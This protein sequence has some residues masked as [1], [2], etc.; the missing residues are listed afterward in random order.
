MSVKNQ[1]QTGFEIAVI[2]MSGRFPG[3]K[4]I[5][6]FWKNLKNGVESIIFFTHE[7]LVEAGVESQLLNDPNFVRTNGGLIENKYC[8]DASFFDYSPREAQI[9]DP[10]LRILHECVWSAIEHAGY[11]PHS[12]DGSIGIYTGARPNFDWE[13]LAVLSGSTSVI[14]AFASEQLTQRDYFNT[15]IAYKL[16]LKGPTML[17]QTACST[18]LVAIHM[19]SRAL[20]MG[21]CNIALAGGVSVSYAK[22]RGYRFIE[23]MIGASDGHVRAFD[24]DATGT[25]GGEGV[26]IIVL[27]RLKHAIADGD[28]IHAVIKGTGVNNDG[29]RK[30]GYTAPSILAQAELVKSVLH[31]AK[32]EPE[33]ITYIEAHGTGTPMG[34]PIEVE[35]LTRAFDTQDRQFCAIGSV[36]TN[37]GHLDAAAGVAG[38]IKTVLALKNKQIPPSLNFKTPNP[39]IDFEN[40]PFFVASTLK[41]WRN[42][43]YPLRAAV[44]SLGIGGTNAHVL[45]E[46]WQDTPASEQDSNSHPRTQTRDI[47][48]TAYQLILLSAKNRSALEKQTN[49]LMKFLEENP[50]VDFADTSYTLQVGRESFKHRNMWTINP[51]CPDFS[52]PW[53]AVASDSN[54]L[55]FMFPG[56]GTQYV[57]M[58]L[59]LYRNFPLFRETIDH[60]F[61]V[62]EP[63]LGYDIKVIL[64]PN[65]SGNKESRLYSEDNIKSQSSDSVDKINRT[66]LTQPLLF[67]IEYALA[68]LLMNWGIKPDAMIGHSIGEYTAACIAGVFSLED[69]LKLVALRGKMMQSMPAGAMLSVELSKKQLDT[70]LVLHPGVTIAAVNAPSLCVV[71]GTFDAIDGLENELTLNEYRCRRLQTSHA[72]HS[73]MMEPILKQFE[74]AVNTV[75]LKSPRQPFISNLTGKWITPEEATSPIY[76]AKHLRQAVQFAD[77]IAQVL[78]E[79]DAI[80]IEVGPSRSLST[81]AKKQFSKTKPQQ[82]VNLVKHPKEDNP[83]DEYLMSKIGQLWLNGVN[84][85]WSAFWREEKRKRIPLPSYPFEET[86]YRLEIDSL[87]E[88]MTELEVDSQLTKKQTL[89]NWFYTP[90]WKRITLPLSQAQESSDPLNWLIFSDEYGIGTQLEMVLKQ[91][92][93][94]NID[95][96]RRGTRFADNGS[97]GFTLN[98]Q[99]SDD[100]HALIQQLKQLDRTPHRIIHLWNLTTEN[101]KNNFSTGSLWHDRAEDNGFYSLVYFAQAMA[102]ENIS[103]EIFLSAVVNNMFEVTGEDALFPLQALVLGPAMVIPREHLNIKCRCI[104]I[105]FSKPGATK[106]KNLITQLADECGAI[107]HANA[108]I[109]AYRNSFR[110]VRTFEPTDLRSPEQEAQELPLKKNG[111]Y[112]VTGGLGGMGLTFAQYLSNAVSASLI[113]ISRSAFP[114]PNE[115]DSWL[116]AHESQDST[117]IK[118]LKLRD[119]EK[120]G[121]HIQVVQADVSDFQKMQSVIGEAE[122]QLGFINGVIHAAG[123]PGDGMIQLKTRE[124]ANNVL[125]PKVKGTLVIDEILQDHPLDFF[126]LCSSMNSILPVFGQ[127]DYYAANAYLDA[128]AQYKAS[129]DGTLV[130]SI[131]WDTWQ[132]VGMAVEAAKKFHSSIRHKQH[133][134]EA[135]NEE[136][137]A[138]FLKDGLMPSEG[139]EVFNRILCGS[140]SQVAVSTIYLPARIKSNNKAP[141]VITGDA[142]NENKSL[143]PMGKRPEINSQ[144]VAP[145]NDHE[146]K[147]VAIWQD[148]L[149]I[150]KIGILDSFFELGGDSLSAIQVVY[151]LKE[152]KINISVDDIFLHQNIQNICRNLFNETDT[153]N[154]S[155]KESEHTSLDLTE[156]LEVKIPRKVGITKEEQKEIFSQLNINDKFTLLLNDNNLKN[157]FPISPN[158]EA[159]LLDPEYIAQKNILF[160]FLFNHPVDE[161]KIKEILLHIIAEN[162]LMRSV[163]ETEGE[164]FTIQEY[165]SFDNIE[166]PII[167]ISAYSGNTQNEILDA[168]NRKFQTDPFK[169][170][171]HVLYRIGVFKLDNTRY[172]LITGFNHLI[173]DGES[174]LILEEMIRNLIDCPKNSNEIA[175]VKKD[176][177]DYIDF[178]NVHDYK[179]INLD[180]F[181]STTQFRQFKQEYV[182]QFPQAQTLPLII[183]TDISLMNNTLKNLYNEVLF[184]CFAKMVSQLFRLDKVPLTFVSKGRQFRNGN[185]SKVI[186]DFHDGI[187]VLLSLN[188]DS[189]YREIIEHFIDYREFVKEE[190]LCFASFYLKNSVA[191]IDSAVLRSPLIYNSHIGVYEAAKNISEEIMTNALIGSEPL[192]NFELTKD[193]FSDKLII[194]IAQNFGFETQHLT[195]VFNE[196]Y[197]EIIQDLNKSNIFEIIGKKQQR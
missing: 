65:V 10:Q 74:E 23:G 92:K 27:K 56:Q 157:Q 96:V 26:G 191:G 119:M 129:K 7:E 111:V 176:Y 12:Y 36:K 195:Q 30:I 34:D 180:K 173:F 79:N 186:G 115:W 156:N 177:N 150:E 137:E 136:F 87:T 19:A 183:E 64:Y 166:I 188:G 89:D 126:V 50:G 172:Q 135:S 97:E 152:V 189:N 86:S 85:D 94:N 104:D 114:E 11:A 98:P 101:K 167:D 61:D 102:K 124:K 103:Q 29:V 28:T 178:L 41:Q 120:A 63:I 163:I 51:T 25:I 18:S 77:G 24:A 164:G 22:K 106:E 123:T 148:M 47:G 57:N 31:L 116:N 48:R 88:M 117:S 146:Q 72:F 128:F 5:D 17:L 71:S 62:L 83:D 81:F 40:S 168:V 60:C 99:Q 112:L 95:V 133:G 127:V 35:A 190:N 1:K 37:I 67:M 75:S 39:N 13:A 130:V 138:D 174:S 196:A 160:L 142:G 45:L 68:L 161:F 110:W 9:M 141:S 91:H 54:R 66:E 59:D 84:I 193:F 143:L 16:N 6:E 169:V 134:E 125:A 155:K 20:L 139:I 43:D 145:Q 15:R 132:E 192:F 194:Y 58:G 171:R 2:G 52:N 147:I 185:F 140:L 80:Y 107:P 93:T 42:S 82:A 184:L 78:E 159:F 131:N 100:Y 182:D 162:V 69:A 14:G 73:Y 21:E 118:I 33:S 181:F 144:Y 187:P 49:N 46:E 197:N 151:R 113:L 109:I 170:L 149:G 105:H 175:A 76:W 53:S 179:E 165:D 44:N 153:S 3:A 154:S 55:I 158:Q 8:F 90:G 38:V 121:S 108:N 32:V 70:I 122:T 4:N